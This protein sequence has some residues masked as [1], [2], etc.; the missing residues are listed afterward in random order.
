MSYD[1][2]IL[3][4][5]AYFS[6]EE[7]NV[8][9]LVLVFPI[10]L[11]AGLFLFFSRWFSVVRAGLRQDGDIRPV[12]RRRRLTGADALLMAVITLLYGATAF[13]GLGD[14]EAPQSFCRFTERGN[15]ALIELPETEQIGSVLY[16]SGL[17]SGNYYLQFSTD[18]ETW[19]DV[20]T[21]EQSHA[22]LFKWQWAELAGENLP[23]KYLRIISDTKLELG[24]LAVYTAD[25]ELLDAD[26]LRY[27]AGTAPLFDE[28]ALIPEEGPSYLN[29][30][31]FDEIYHAR[32][33]YENLTN[34]YPYEV[35]HPP[36]G[37]LIISIGLHLFGMTPFG[38]RFM[39]TLFGVLMLPIFYIFLK[40]LFGNTPIAA[41]GTMLFAFDFMHFVQTRIATID[42]YAVFFI[43]LMYLFMYLFVSYDRDA[44]DARPGRQNLYLALS[45]LSFG[46]GAASKWTC[47]YAG[48]GLAVIWLLYWIFRGRALHRT[49]RG[50][51][52]VDEL[53]PNIVLCLVFFLLLPCAI[54][55]ASYYPYGKARG[56]SGLSMYTSK[57][58]AKIVLDNQKFMFTYH[59]GV[60]DSHPYAS[61]WYQWIVDGRPILYYL[62]Y[63]TETTKSAFAAFL[64]PIVCWGGLLALF[65]V[66]WLGIR[67]RD[68]K[69]LFIVIGYM[70]QFLPWLLISR[71]T[72]A[73][74]YFPCVPFL[75]ICICYVFDVLRGLDA[76][77]KRQLALFTAV[78]TALFV[79]FYPALTGVEIP[80]WYSKYFLHWI[81]GAWPI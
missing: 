60:T 78:G 13:T 52:L 48:A 37:K 27:D 71:I 11:L 40:K 53:I 39:G 1:G 28:Q 22:D 29:S 25:G 3:V 57:E 21:M 30:A 32:T 61:R 69:A 18:G 80:T 77:W 14:R 63:P 2:I 54:Y 73:Y 70:A 46:L 74:H 26:S 19:T 65:A 68:K 45:G 79:M 33:A 20:A 81:P 75:V 4:I 47:I 24:E 8:E 6:R 16:Y 51:R 12:Y 66:I 64:N 35:S 67:R 17:Y 34:V 38:W 59:A 5:S 36:L 43:L 50:E 55:Y 15:Y 44:P 56:M 58:Y 10:A 76:H 41:A 31:Y 49:G 62:D 23:A 42:T 72:F 7:F 9:Y